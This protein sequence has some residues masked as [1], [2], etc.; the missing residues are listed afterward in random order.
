VGIIKDF[1]GTSLR[2]K[3]QPVIIST[4]FR[5]FG[6]VL[7]KY[8]P[9]QTA[10]A[11]LAVES[12]YKKF[13]PEFPI[14]IGFLDETFADLYGDEI[15]MGRLATVCTSIAIFISCLG[16][17]GL[18]SFSAERR[19]KE[20]GIR[21]VLGADVLRIVS[22]LCLDT[23]LLLLIACAVGVPLALWGASEFLGRFAFHT[24]VNYWAVAAVACLM[25]ALALATIS[26]Q[27]VK[28]ARTNPSDTLRS[29]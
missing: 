20:I 15:L 16:L 1:H 28:A 4:R 14:E 22:L 27:S 12:V 25:I 5:D 19:R 26:M 2:D 3:L 21:K 13:E 8:E 17:F 9:G 10:E 18:I 7:V 24:S 23:V 6:I 11:M 29:E